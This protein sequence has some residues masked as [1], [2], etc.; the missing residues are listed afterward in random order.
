MQGTSVGRTTNWLAALLLC[1]V[2]GSAAADRDTLLLKT[3]PPNAQVYVVRRGKLIN[4]AANAQLGDLV[5]AGFRID[6][7]ELVGP[8]GKPLVFEFPD[9]QTSVTVLL[10]HRHCEP[11]VQRLDIAQARAGDSK[12]KIF[13]LNQNRYEL[14]YRSPAHRAAD[15]WERYG[16]WVAALGAV[17]FLPL[18][19]HT[20]KVRRLARVAEQ[21]S[22]QAQKI[23]SMVV[24]G[25]FEDPLIGAALDE[26]RILEQL[27]QGGMAK[28]YRAVPD[29]PELD[30][31]RSVAIK[32]LSLELAQDE[33]VVRRFDREKRIY[34]NLLHPNIVKVYG[35]GVYQQQY[36]LVME[37]I[38]G[39]TMRSEVVPG[40]QSPRKVLKLM[41]PVLE[42]VSFANKKGVTHRDLK[43]ENIMITERGDVK[44]MDFGL[45]R[46]SQFSQVT[47]TGSILGTPA[48]MA[49]EQIQGEL[50]T[51]SDQYSLGVILYELLCGEPP[52]QDENPVT[53]VIKHISQPVPPL[54]A[55]KAEL[56]AVGKAVERMLEKDPAQR[57][58]DLDHALVS[59]RHVML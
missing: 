23:T 5:P 30:S 35:S 34:E 9:G 38:R 16:V 14:T 33:E 46:G 29:G 32:L 56:A 31:S 26:Y 50:D 37:Y 51:R 42:A 59:L 7:G 57:Y 43:P 21:Q 20:R 28:V 24:K 55:K 3:D 17:I 4:E 12:I 25:K 15:L 47:A 39:T 27:G 19:L 41:T 58:R 10:L 52:F 53:L 54:A 11:N 13:P 8:A 45:A 1:L 40:G 18:I 6:P 36:Y 44:V 2:A 49:P 22:E 48:Y